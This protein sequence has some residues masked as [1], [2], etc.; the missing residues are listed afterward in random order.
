M[1]I[2]I[3]T[4]DELK[5]FTGVSTA[6]SIESMKPH[7]AFSWS[8]DEVIKVLGPTLYDNLLTAYTDETL[9]EVANA[10]L[11]GLL[12]HVQKPLASLSVYSFMQEGGVSI[13]DQGITA[14]RD[15]SA[16]QWQQLKAEDYYIDSAYRSL[17]R[18]IKFL[19]SNA[20]DY[21]DWT[22]TAYHNL[23]KDLLIASPSV[24]SEYVNIKDSYRTF[25]A[26]LPVLRQSELNYIS[27]AISVT[28]FAALKA[29][30]SNPSA[31]DKLVLDYLKPALAFLTMADAL[32]DLNLDY[33]G[34]GA[35]VHS[36]KANTENIKEKSKPKAEDLGRAA[37][38]FKA[39]GEDKLAQLKAYL[40]GAASSTKYPLY[41][42]SDLYES[43]E[44]AEILRAQP[45]VSNLY[46]ALK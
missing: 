16:F 39:K 3:K 38:R 41:F 2:L 40:D 11:K 23:Q 22:D 7:L 25:I 6:L 30:L 4:E 18:L 35:Y 33:T 8:E 20:A 9:E 24:F 28:Y 37:L 21:A 10:S 34:D 31:D 15:R 5:S 46:N 26:L 12:P 14:N 17:D 29:S 27:P 43:E 42:A 19:L 1:K 32:N 36:L 44:D 13:E 45:T